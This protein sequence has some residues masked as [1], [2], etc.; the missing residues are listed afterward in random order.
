MC[1]W[2]VVSIAVPAD[3]DS[4]VTAHSAATMAGVVLYAIS[5]IMALRAKIV[6]AWKAVMAINLVLR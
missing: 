2:G 6:L 5:V 4:V 3:R 1:G